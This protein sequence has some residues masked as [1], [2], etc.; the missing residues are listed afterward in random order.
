MNTTNEKAASCRD[1]PAYASI[2]KVVLTVH[3]KY[4]IFDREKIVG[5]IAILAV[6]VVIGIAIGAWCFGE[7]AYATCWVMCKP[8]S[9]V[10]IRATPDKGGISEGWLDCGDSFETDA[11]TEEGWIHC[12]GVGDA[13]EGWIYLGYVTTR[14]PEKV[15]ER[16]VCVANNRVA[17]RKWMAGPQIDERPWMY[18]G[19]FCEVFITDGEWAVTSRGYIK[20]EW[21]EVSVE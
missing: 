8:G 7:E 16:Y 19:E 18:N 14:K 12:I 21:L 13:E 15:G 2:R 1:Q 10:E 4:S 9:R 11:E 6:A 20:A 17:C 5:F 3:R